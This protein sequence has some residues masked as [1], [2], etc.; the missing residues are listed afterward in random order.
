MNGRTITKITQ[1]AL[2]NPPMSWLR[3]MS[4]ITVN[5]TPEEEDEA[6]EPEHRPEEV[7]QRVGVGG[8]R[9]APFRFLCRRRA[10]Y[11]LSTSPRCSCGGGE[12]RGQ[13]D[14]RRRRI[15]PTSSLGTAPGCAASATPPRQARRSGA[16]SGGRRYHA[17]VGTLA[18]VRAEALGCT[19]CALA[20]GRTQVVFGV[21]D[22]AARLM[23]V[24]EGPGRDE[25]LA[26]E[27]FVGRSGKLLDKLMEQELGIDR[28]AVLHR[29]CGEVPPAGQPR[30]AARTRSTRAARTSR[31][32]SSSSTRRSWSRWAT[33]PP[34][35]CSTPSEGITPRAGPRLPVPQ[36]A[37]G[38][39]VP[40]GGRVARRRRGAGRDAR[41]LRAG[42][43]A[44]AAA[45]R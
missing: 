32:S 10:T 21:G 45:G 19:R 41:R 40:P 34:G 4:R 20:A 3:K 14:P 36:R 12:C 18:D 7:E 11:S 5:S 24:G 28:R 37:P 31:R 8:E 30:P 1:P 6:E 17:A 42:Q 43:A 16:A 39:D 38:A 25:D 22:D 23:F 15:G 27:P 26:G 2:A 35:C 44:A 13:R 9:V 29:Q 33:S